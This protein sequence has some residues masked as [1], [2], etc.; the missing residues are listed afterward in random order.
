MEFAIPDELFVEANKSFRNDVNLCWAAASCAA[1]CMTG[2]CKPTL[3]VLDCE[4][5]YV[6]GELAEKDV[7]TPYYLD[8]PDALLRYTA[9]YIKD[10]G[11]L[12]YMHMMW[13]IC[14]STCGE[15]NILKKLGG[16]RFYFLSAQ[17]TIKYISNILPED[18]ADTFEKWGG[19][20]ETSGVNRVAGTAS[21]YLNAT[22]FSPLNSSYNSLG[23]HEVSL[24]G[25]AT[26]GGK[27][28]AVQIADP[29][30]EQTARFWLDCK[31]D[32]RYHLYLATPRDDSPESWKNK[33]S[34][35]LYGVTLLAGNPGFVCAKGDAREQGALDD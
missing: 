32:P 20:F 29:D 19:N 24:W 22:G 27:V 26:D 11:W 34:M 15:E 33:K 1:L 23:G 3:R 31:Y 13:F 12:G 7:P 14:G 16:G 18:F 2:W 35:W 9:Q 21:F 25:F 8:S 28:T 17:E 4:F 30:D 5:D 10:T 6:Y